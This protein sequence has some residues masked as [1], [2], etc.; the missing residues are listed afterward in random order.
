MLVSAATTI[1]AEDS[2]EA[3]T[4]PPKP[5][6]FSLTIKAGGFDRVAHIQIP[7]GY[8]P[9]V[10]PPLV[11]LLHG[12]G[13]N[14]AG[15]LDKDEWAAKA[16]KEGFVAV[17]PDGLP[18]LPR[19]PANFRTNPALWNSGQLRPR[20]P[21]AAIDDVAYIR[22]LLDELKEKVP[23]DESRVL[24]AGH[25][26]GDG[27]TFRLASELSERFTALGMVAGMNDSADTKPKKPLPMLYIVG[28]KDPLTPIDGGDVK[29]PWGHRQNVPV[30]DM[31]ADWAKLMGCETEP[32][33]TS[34]KDG[35]KTVEY[36]PKSSGAKLSVIY[37]DGQGHNWPG[38][39]SALPESMVGP[40]TD[41]L[42]ATNAL[43]DF[44]VAQGS[45]PAK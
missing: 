23:Y 3:L 5:G 12:A 4:V 27:M 17:A 38:G 21:R 35:V 10:K 33:T 39:K 36:A 26:N 44:F 28:T 7:A 34:D 16:D 8:R 19:T 29:L 18:A 20:S 2:E 15:I 1:R 22:Q 11:L 42:D 24:C 30:A 43:W 45:H 41:K 37:I 13:G 31:L 14:G 25:S 9:D 6:R 40:S 32:K